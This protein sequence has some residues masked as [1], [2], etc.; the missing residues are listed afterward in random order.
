[1]NATT[2]SDN[3]AAIT[4]FFD[5]LNQGVLDGSEDWVACLSPQVIDHR[6]TSPAPPLRAFASSWRRS[7]P[8]TPGKAACWCRT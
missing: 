3:K 1:M 5:S 6:P 8:P 2:V 4:A 7:V